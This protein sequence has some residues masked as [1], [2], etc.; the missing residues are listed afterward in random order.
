MKRIQRYESFKN[1]RAIKEEFIGKFWRNLTGK[2]KERAKRVDSFMSRD[3]KPYISA[4]GV[5]EI[6]D[7]PGTSMVDL[8]NGL[9][10]KISSRFSEIFLES[11]WKKKLVDSLKP[12]EQESGPAARLMMSVLAAGRPDYSEMEDMSDAEFSKL[13]QGIANIRERAGE[14]IVSARRGLA[15][16]ALK[17]AIAEEMGEEEKAAAE[18]LSKDPEPPASEVLDGY[19]EVLSWIGILDYED[20]VKSDGFEIGETG[21]S[22]SENIGTLVKSLVAFQGKPYKSDDYI[23]SRPDIYEDALGKGYMDKIDFGMKIEDVPRLKK[24]RQELQERISWIE[25]DMKKSKEAAAA[26]KKMNGLKKAFGEFAKDAGIP[27]KIGPTE[28]RY[29]LSRLK[30]FRNMVE[31]I[32]AELGSMTIEEFFG[33]LKSKCGRFAERFTTS[34]D[35]VNEYAIYRIKE[36]CGKAYHGGK[37]SPTDLGFL[38]REQGGMYGGKLMTGANNWPT[39]LGT[40]EGGLLSIK[41]TRRVY[42]MSIKP[43]TKMVDHNPGGADHGSQGGLLDENRLYTPHGIKGM[44]NKWYMDTPDGQIPENLGSISKND[45]IDSALNSEVVVLEQDACEIRIVPFRE[46]MAEYERLGVTDHWR[47]KEMKLSYPRWRDMAWSLESARPGIISDLKP[48]T[49]MQ[50]LSE[51]DRLVPRKSDPSY[52]APEG[53]KADELVEICGSVSVK[54]GAI[55]KFPTLLDY[56]IY[57]HDL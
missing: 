8:E 22:R 20:N 36:G 53:E 46:V 25:S 7:I 21:K 39:I 6:S 33:M 51:I 16:S 29:G 9:K 44:A 40:K 12:L 57:R 26:A 45:Y 35:Y 37:I 14:M 23:K 19:D 38:F 43:G 41:I 27:E 30:T 11:G 49:E 24:L 42:E 32:F 50:D 34:E 13:L 15:E 5:P 17:K 56:I 2:N 4:G 54:T 48:F 31:Y 55:S 10:E 1:S 3:G 47:Y 28:R 18:F 52:K